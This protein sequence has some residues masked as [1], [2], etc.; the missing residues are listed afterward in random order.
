MAAAG[1]V[2]LPG[3]RPPLIRAGGL[4]GLMS[5][6]IGVGGGVVMV[7]AMTSARVGLSQ[8]VAT[9]TSLAAIVPIAVAGA[10]TYSGARQVD[11]LAA[12]CVIPGSIVGAILGARLTRHIPDRI[13]A[14][15]FALVSAAV[16]VRLLI[17]A[18]LSS[19]GQ[20]VSA[21]AL[22]VIELAGI[23]VIVGILSGL[24]GI[25]GGLLTVPILTL[26]YGV[27]QQ[28]AQGTSL[29]AIVPTGLSGAVTHQRM[30]HLHRGAAVVLGLCGIVGAVAGGLLATHLPE[31]VLRVAFAAYLG[32]TAVR[33]V[34][35]AR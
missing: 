22:H 10:L 28:L 4:A 8:R 19:G 26:G 31:T 7:P 34:V 23:G 13:L 21:T 5:G 12:V 1:A 24:L 15:T 35:G 16:A 6:L 2:A 17:P 11:G 25:G 14:I 29:A 32:I 18:G 20:P 27:S 3:W 33:I 30:G 9:G